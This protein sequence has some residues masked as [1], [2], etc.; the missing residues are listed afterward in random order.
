M[1][2]S[3]LEKELLG[4]FGLVMGCFFGCFRGR[5]VDRRSNLVSKTLVSKTTEP[6]VSR[7]RLSSLLQAEEGKEDSE[8]STP[9]QM[10]EGKLLKDEAR[11]LKA[12]GTIAQTPVEIQK[13]SERYKY[14]SHSGEGSEPF[15]FHSWRPST[16]I[17][18]LNLE[19]QLNQPPTPVKFGEGCVN[20]AEP[21]EHTPISPTQADEG[22]GATAGTSSTRT[23]S[24]TAVVASEQCRNK[25]VRFECNDDMAMF[26]ST[27]SS[28]EIGGI[29]SKQLASGG[30]RSVSKPEPYPTPL[31]LTDEMQ[32]P[33]T[34][35][36]ANFDG[37]ARRRNPRIRSQ[38]V[39]SAL[40]PVENISQLKSLKEEQGSSESAESVNLKAEVKMTEAFV[41]KEPRVEESLSSWLK[42]PTANPEVRKNLGHTPDDRPIIGIVAA[43]WN[44]EVEASRVSPKDWDGNG[45]PNSTHK[46]K[47]DQKVSW[48]ATPFEERLEK[49]LSDESS[50]TRRNGINA[51]PQLDFEDTDENDTALS[52]LQPSTYA[53]PMVSF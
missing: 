6:V 13:V 8:F 36:P 42:P 49:A 23:P 31:K 14:I 21:L 1:L 11:F 53:K 47:E 30:V 24:G 37:M 44:E 16:S 41:E 26:S 5:H 46:Y 19:K 45:I 43:H 15:R 28:S 27:N 35:F 2:C 50:I 48:H 51:S 25:S 32:T 39:Y 9:E 52:P 29:Y 40:N 12:T 38:Y 7:N 33:G 4:F 10:N 22:A 17:E 3:V 34:V 20:K 18:K